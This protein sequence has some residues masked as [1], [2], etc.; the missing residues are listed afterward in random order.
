MI[1]ELYQL[2]VAMKKAGISVPNWHRKYKLI[3][4]AT[5]NA[6]CFKLTAENGH[7]LSIDSVPKELAASLRKYGSNQGTFPCMNLVPLYR[8]TDEQAK[9]TI[10]SMHA[11]QIDENTLRQIDS[12]CAQNNWAPKFRNK[13]KISMQSVPDELRKFLKIQTFDPISVLLDD[14]S[15]FSDPD[16]LHAEMKRAAFEMLRRK[17]NINL[18]L[19]ILFHLGSTDKKPEDDTGALSVAF[20][21]STLIRLGTPAVSNQFTIGFNQFLMSADAEEKNNTASSLIDAFGQSFSPIEEPMPSVKLAGGFEV[22][23]RTMFNEQRCQYRYGETENASYPISPVLRQELQAALA[24]ISGSEQKGTYWINTDKEEILFVYPHTLPKSKIS[25]ISPF[26][27]TDE[28]SFQTAAKEFLS[29]ILSLRDTVEESL[30]E[31]IQL[32]ILKKISRGQTKVVYSR[33]TSPYQL[34]QQGEEWVSGCLNNL[35]PF[36]FKQFQ[37][38]YPLEVADI[39]NYSWKQDGTITT[40]RFKPVHKYRGMELLLEPDTPIQQD[41]HMLVQSCTAIAPYLGSHDEKISSIL[42]KVKQQIS[43]LGFLLY[44]MQIRKEHY[45]NSF[46]FQY[47]QLLKAADELHILY[48][49]I[50]RNGDFPVQLVGSGLYRAATEAPIRTLDLLQ[51]RMAPYTVWAK[52]YRM[53]NESE[54]GLAGWLYSVIEKTANQLSKEWA[55]QVRLNDA[56]K[57]QM[58]L[59]Y[60]GSL[61]HSSKETAVDNTENEDTL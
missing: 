20:E 17:E 43:L 38:P 5:E 61:P 60:L 18:A 47:G 41:L 33:L 11:E 7:L 37:V 4:K 6:P 51:Q 58:F 9:K 29:S 23:L 19:L 36:H 45:M 53:K 22:T 31:N 52:T 15:S 49:R 42:W 32:F 35:P 2:S 13:Y 10:S 8:I 54:S 55:D 57:A 48:C 39:L 16:Q 3:P 14:V 40:D 28:L 44:R 56:D 1:N 46:P 34:K 21:S 27:K 50:V 30:A 12:W 24:W 25:F 59:G 26:K